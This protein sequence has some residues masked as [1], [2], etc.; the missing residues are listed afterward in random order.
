MCCH[1]SMYRSGMFQWKNFFLAHERLAIIDPTSGDQPLF[2]EGKTIAVAVNGEIYN[3]KSLKAAILQKHPNKK[4]ATQSDCEV[5][6]HLYEDQGDKVASL[7]DG[8]FSFVILDS[9]DGSFYAARDPIGITSLYIGWG[10]DGSVWLASEMKCLKDE[11]VRFQQFPPG[12]YFSSKDM[13]SSKTQG[14]TRYYNPQFY[15]DFEASP[16]RSPSTPYDP[17]VLREA[18]EA[19]VI[20]RMMSDVPFGVLL[21]GGLDSSLVAAIASRAIKSQDTVW[22]NRLHSFCIGLP[23]SPD[24]KAGREVAQFLGT[25]HHEFTFTVQEGIDA[26]SDVIQHIE[27][28]D[29]TTIR[30][31]TPMFLMSR[32]IKALGVKMVLSGEGSDEVFGGYLYFHKAPNKDEFFQETVRKVQALHQ[33][34]CLRANKS[35]MAWGVEARV[36]FLDRNF[37][38]V[39]MA[40]DPTEKMIDRSKAW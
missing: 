37:L 12:H 14:F 20:K 34:D 30:A 10:K 39:A 22:G 7:L 15:L 33:Y 26:I 2:N 40:I 23:G 16:P 27:T 4:F 29:V 35:T 19:A 11:C 38:D 17:K 24:L 36:P 31:S 25:D 18:F 8:M 28:Y 5:I 6:S 1:F 32:K 21:S 9:R 3:H 13:G